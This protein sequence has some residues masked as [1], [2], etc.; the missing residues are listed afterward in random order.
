MKKKSNA[1]QLLHRNYVI[2]YVSCFMNTP[3]SFNLQPERIKMPIQP[4]IFLV[5]NRVLLQ[6]SVFLCLLSFL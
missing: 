1:Q 2:L 6:L 3:K 5:I 4:R